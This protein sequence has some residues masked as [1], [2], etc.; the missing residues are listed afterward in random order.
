MPQ[1][2]IGN[3]GRFY[4]SKTERSFSEALEEKLADEI[5][6]IDD[7]VGDEPALGMQ[8]PFVLGQNV[9]QG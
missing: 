5:L 2:K 8:M 6:V 3:I 4:F 9:C 7:R 1:N